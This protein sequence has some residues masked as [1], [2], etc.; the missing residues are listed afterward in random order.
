[1]ILYTLCVCGGAFLG[2]LATTHLH[3]VITK[4]RRERT[5]SRARAL[6]RTAEYRAGDP[7]RRL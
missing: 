5:T 2:G 7:F 6:V 1:M 3:T 4:W